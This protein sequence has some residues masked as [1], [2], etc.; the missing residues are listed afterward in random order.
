MTRTAQCSCGALRVEV[1][2]E[3]GAVVLCHCTECQCL[4]GS[5]FGVGAYFP[6]DKVKCTG[7]NTAYTRVMEGRKFTSHFCPT[8]G[9]S[10]YWE[11]ELVPG[12]IGVAVGGFR[13]SNFPRPTRAV[14]EEKRHHWVTLGAEIPGHLQ[15]RT[16]K[17]VR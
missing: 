17:T 12:A 9:T 6:A 13:D 1:E 7:A 2:G 5:V 11:A 15:G 14:W 10:L 4:T 16:S 8:C 3:P